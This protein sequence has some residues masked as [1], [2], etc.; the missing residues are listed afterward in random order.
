MT[1]T[2]LKHGRAASPSDGYTVRRRGSPL[3]QFHIEYTEGDRQLRYYLE[4]LAAGATDE[5]NPRDVGPWLPPYEEDLLSADRQIQIAE[6][7]VAAMLFLGD[8]VRLG[9]Q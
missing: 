4:N 3:T 8:R 2:K 6:R 5:I 7:M 9:S 1:L